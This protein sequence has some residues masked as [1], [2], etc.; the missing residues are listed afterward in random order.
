MA[1]HSNIYDDPNPL[2]QFLI[3]VPQGNTLPTSYHKGE[4]YTE[5][6]E[7]IVPP[8]NGDEDPLYAEP[9]HAISKRNRLSIIRMQ[10]P[11]DLPPLPPVDLAPPVPQSRPAAAN[12]LYDEPHPAGRSEKARE[13]NCGERKH[14]A[15]PLYD[16]DAQM[17][18]ISIPAKQSKKNPLYIDTKPL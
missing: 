6:V 15:N 11:M 3:P 13:N 16:S 9:S 8:P 10:R 5:P 18:D 7:T 1:R 12:L 14:K 17:T 2:K 4:Y